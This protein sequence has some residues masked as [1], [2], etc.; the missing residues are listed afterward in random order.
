VARNTLLLVAK[1]FPARWL[2]YVAYRQLAWLV[3]AARERRLAAFLR[4]AASAMPLLPAMLRERRALR[5]AAAV[6]IHVVVPHR[7]IR[8]P[9]A[10][11]HPRAA[12]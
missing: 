3:H 8:G 12:A 6:P 9:A 11:G 10:G 5:R 4:G 2:P 1:A 7:P